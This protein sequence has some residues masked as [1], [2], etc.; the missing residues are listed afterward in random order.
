MAE[1]TRRKQEVT[2]WAFPLTEDTMDFDALHAMFDEAWN[3]KENTL[4]PTDVKVM[5]DT[6]AYPERLVIRQTTERQVPA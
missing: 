3:A 2:T 5:I 6:E 1:F 4:S